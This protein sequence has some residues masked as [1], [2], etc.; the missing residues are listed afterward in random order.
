MLIY[1]GSFAQQNLLRSQLG[2]MQLSQQ[3]L[4]DMREIRTKVAEI[5]SQTVST[6]VCSAELS[7][8]NDILPT[9]KETHLLKDDSNTGRWECPSAFEYIF[10]SIYYRSTKRPSIP[11]NSSRQDDISVRI[12]TPAWLFR[13][14]YEARATRHRWNWR[15]NFR[16]HYIVPE[17][18]P[19][20]E[21]ARNG[22]IK[23]MQGLFDSRQ[24]TPFDRGAKYGTTALHVGDYI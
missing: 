10:G 16:V 18:T 11:S 1:T 2:Q 19:L 9:P 4:H 24:A 8:C 3:L 22:D 15:F 17:N 6:T 13:K 12:C 5:P 23:G 7:S 14:V 21:Y 20:F